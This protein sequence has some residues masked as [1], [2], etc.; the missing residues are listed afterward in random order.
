MNKQEFYHWESASRDTIDVKRIYIDIA[1]DLIAGILLSQIIFWH[2]PDKNGKSKLR[3]RHE[4]KFWLAK[5]RRSWNDE[6]RIGPRQ[7]DK[8]I[9]I[10]L[11][12]KLVES[13]VFKFAGNPTVHIRLNEEV[14]LASLEGKRVNSISPNGDNQITPTGFPLTENTCIN[15]NTSKIKNEAISSQSSEIPEASELK[16]RQEI[17]IKKPLSSPNPKPEVV[18]CATVPK[19][20]T[21]Y[22]TDRYNVFVHVMWKAK[23]GGKPKSNL[24]E[25][26][27]L[28][29]EYGVPTVEKSFKCYLDET[30]A[31]YVSLQS[32]CSKFGVWLKQSGGPILTQAEKDERDAKLYQKPRDQSVD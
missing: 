4:D 27:E 6:C 22:P 18:S 7:Y 17:P 23:C 24:K 19:C 26:K 10:L 5:T 1:G 31:K 21:K 2:L 13:K 14:F 3:V 29:G 30:E 25:I 8:A 32:F 16:P 12:A 20:L 11:D 15:N 28:C 9:K